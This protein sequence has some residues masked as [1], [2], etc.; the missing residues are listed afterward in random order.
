MLDGESNIDIAVG[1]IL[2]VVVFAW[3]ITKPFA[4]PRFVLSLYIVK[5]PSSL[6]TKFEPANDDVT[7]ILLLVADGVIETVG[8][9]II[10]IEK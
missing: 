5:Y 8:E 9:I 2:C 6:L 1:A 7:N 10:K 3:I 4:P